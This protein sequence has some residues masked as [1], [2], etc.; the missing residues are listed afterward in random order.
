MAIS[1]PGRQCETIKQIMR[2]TELAWNAVCKSLRNESP[3]V[4]RPRTPRPMQ[5]DPYKGYLVDRIAS[6]M[7]Y[8]IPAT[9]PLRKIQASGSPGGIT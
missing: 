2:R 3:S 5:L 4:H 9:V 6:A 7:L 8:W 1:V